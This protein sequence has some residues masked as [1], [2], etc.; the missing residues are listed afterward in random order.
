MENPTIN[1]RRSKV[2][3]IRI[4]KQVYATMGPFMKMGN[5]II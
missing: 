2:Y 1:K 3:N 4:N 5:V